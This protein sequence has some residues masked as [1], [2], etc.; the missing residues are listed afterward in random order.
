MLNVF[1]TVDTEFWPLNSDLRDAC[2]EQDV[3]R[4]FYGAVSGAEFGLGFQIDMLNAHGLKAVFFVESLFALAVGPDALRQVVSMIQD[5]GQD[6][7]LH[8]HTEWLAWMKDSILPARTGQNMK[9]FSEDE[10][11]LL[12]AHGLRNLREA[13]APKVCAFR[14]GNF[15]ANLDTLRALRRNGICYDSS[16]NVQYLNSDCGIHTSQLLLQ[17][18]E[19]QGVYEFPISFF[20]DGRGHYRH[21]QLSA[22]SF[23]EI[24]NALLEA[25]Q[26]GWNSFVL[27]SHSFELLKN[28]MLPG[29]PVVADRI[30]IRRFERLCRF[31][32]DNRDKFR[33]AVFSETVPGMI[34]PVSPL[35]PLRCAW[36]HT[37]WRLAEQLTRRLF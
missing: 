21:A 16:Y 12:V 13:G 7:Q 30:V 28:R 36:H 5:R 20:R 8:V 18:Q 29:K 1:L 19:M 9:D 26:S 34:P 15:G 32:S 11:T 10:Q 27:V 2:L 14:A 31:L 3:A 24:K 4:D 6:V 37:A 23:Q 25:W 35:K 22:C 17:P 33:T